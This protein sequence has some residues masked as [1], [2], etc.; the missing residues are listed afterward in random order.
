M[1]KDIIGTVLDVFGLAAVSAAGFVITLWLGLLLVGLS[2]LVLSYSLEIFPTTHLKTSSL[3]GHAQVRKREPR[4]RE[5][6]LNSSK[7]GVFVR[8]T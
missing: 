5:R 7:A 2:L 8:V 1:T 3:L 6:T 4:P